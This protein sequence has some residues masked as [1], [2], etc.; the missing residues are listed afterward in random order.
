MEQGDALMLL[1]DGFFEWQRPSDGECF[2]IE[3][4]CDAMIGSV[5]DGG[6]AAAMIRS[7]DAAVT[8]FADG[9][10]Q[11]DDMTAVVIRR[12]AASTPDDGK[13]VSVDVPVAPAVAAPAVAAAGR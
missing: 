6:L 4:L 5:R 1:T 2:G 7:I 13:A 12:T 10:P 9:A 11:S 8:K 3:R